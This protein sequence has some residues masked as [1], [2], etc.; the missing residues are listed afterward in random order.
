MKIKLNIILLLI[1]LSCSQ[2]SKTNEFYN[3]LNSEKE[4]LTF[5]FIVN[6]SNYFIILDNNL[7]NEHCNTIDKK[8]TQKIIDIF[9]Q[10]GLLNI[11]HAYL[12]KDMDNEQNQKIA[13]S[14]KL[15]ILVEGNESNLFIMIPNVELAQKLL[16]QIGTE[17]NYS[18]CFTK[19][20]NEI[21]T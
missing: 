15:M 20:S 19:L 5:T 1:C 13:E 3:F 8:S 2:D 18:D 12:E 6:F 11:D 14:R 21:K 7:K 16:N 9:N 17:L 10:N 4:S